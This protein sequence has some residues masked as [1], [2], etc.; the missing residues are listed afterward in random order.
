MSAWRRSMAIIMWWR[1][2]ISMRI[3]AVVPT[4]ES[5]SNILAA[6]IARTVCLLVIPRTMLSAI[7]TV[8]RIVICARMGSVVMSAAAI[9]SIWPQIVPSCRRRIVVVGTS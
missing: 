3:A 1:T 7:V 6:S 4:I 8:A 9:V 2:P 5:P